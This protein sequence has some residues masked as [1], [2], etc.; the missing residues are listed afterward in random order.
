MN[1]ALV[2]LLCCVAWCTTTYAASAVS[3]DVND[4]A[5]DAA[6]EP[7]RFA[8]VIGHNEGEVGEE[9]LRYARVDAE[10]MADVLLRLGDVRATDLVTLVDDRDN[11][12]TVIAALNELELRIAQVNGP[13]LLV[14][15]YSGHA[16]QRALHLGRSP[17]QLRDL[18][19]RLR[20]SRAAAR[21]L[22]LDACRSG[23]L[24][25]VKGGEAAAP[26]IDAVGYA[27]VTASAAGEDAAESD[28]LQGSFFTHALTSALSGAADDD[29]DR[30]IT[31]TEA[32]DYAFNRT[33]K[34][35]TT[36]SAGVQHP[37]FRYDL[38]GRSDL[39]LTRF[40]DEQGRVFASA[41]TQM[42]LFS[43]GRV[44]AELAA[45]DANRFLVVAP[46]TYA[47]VARSD[48]TLFEGD[49]VVVAGQTTALN[50]STLKASS[51]ARL[52]RKGHSEQPLV[53]GVALGPSTTV[54]A[55]P[56]S[57]G[58]QLQ[59]PLA[60]PQLT[61]TPQLD[62]S[63]G[64]DYF[65]VDSVTDDTVAQR[66]TSVRLTSA[67]SLTWDASWVSLSAGVVGGVH[68]VQQTTE[69]TWNTEPD[70]VYAIGLTGGVDG[71]AQVSLPGRW[72]VELG[73]G[74]G[75]SAVTLV[76]GS[77]NVLLAPRLL[78]GLWL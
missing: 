58:V 2:L 70:V 30:R 69:R 33:V 78:L 68:V 53:A 24:T 48:K 25:R 45:N 62:L 63:S 77:T 3:A 52:V 38:R 67:L 76:P 7:R 21:L 26:E 39:V 14:V 73:S 65:L 4:A 5:S 32:Y 71:A 35:S 17:L 61:I 66:Y 64:A 72:F 59:V 18:D 40:D 19:E 46:G 13:T 75:V 56:W 51:F 1:R 74:L 15:Y 50:V 57:W 47:V 37:T 29:G 23:S 44:V 27:V 6:N 36:S 16:S 20:Q 41:R 22:I 31:L 49:L 55:L 60:L 34:L 11:A 10:R 28:E 8:L 43:S 54:S 12:D 42:V 9:P